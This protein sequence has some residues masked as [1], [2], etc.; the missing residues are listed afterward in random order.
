M[1]FEAHDKAHSEGSTV[2]KRVP[3][4]FIGQHR[5]GKTSVKNSLRGQ[6]FKVN[7]DS[8]AGKDENSSSFKMSRE[9][10]KVGEKDKDA[11]YDSAFSFEHHLAR[12]TVQYLRYRTI[13]LEPRGA[14]S[15]ESSNPKHISNSPESKFTASDVTHTEIH[16]PDMTTEMPKDHQ[17]GEK[18]ESSENFTN[19]AHGVSDDSKS[20]EFLRS[21]TEVL[22]QMEVEEEDLYSMLWDFNGESINHTTYPVFLTHKAVYILVYDLSQNATAIAKPVIKQGRYR[23]RED[24]HFS[25]TNLDYLKFWMSSVAS[26]ASQHVNN[27]SNSISEV[28]PEKL[29]PV[30]LVFT[31]ADTLGDDVDA[32]KI[33]RDVYGS[34]KQTPS[35]VH[36]YKDFFVV[37]TT[38]SGQEFECSEIVRLRKEVL[39]VCSELP[40]LRETIPIQSLIFEKAIQK[41]K[42]EGH[43]FVSLE[44]ARLLAFEECNISDEKQFQRAI[45]FLHEQRILI[46]FDET[47]EL[48]RLVILD[49][50]WLLNVFKGVMS[51]KLYEGSENIFEHLWRKLETEGILEE[52][53]LEYVWGPLHDK[54]NTYESL[55]A[56]M[57]KFSLICPLPSLDHSCGKMYL[58]PSMLMS[59][60]TEGITSLVAAARIPPIFLTFESGQVPSGLFLR[61]ALQL[62][63]WNRKNNPNSANFNFYSNYARFY[64]SVKEKCSVILR[65]YSSYIEVVVHGNN[66]NHESEDGSRSELDLRG[67]ESLDENCARAVRRQL[68]VI[69]NSMHSKFFWPKNTTCRVSF[70]CP[71]CCQ[72]GGIVER[73]KFHLE[74]GC[75]Q[76]ECLHFLSESEICSADIIYCTRNAVAQE[77]R[78]RKEQFEP[79]IKTISQQVCY[80]REL[81]T[82]SILI[83]S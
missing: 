39:A 36:L 15:S 25:K 40:Q 72:N 62:V 68:D 48:N 37:D 21:L 16:D 82:R 24:S 51:V 9:I 58:E 45:N 27:P 6:P 78:V 69:V 46:H 64:P 19:T 75:K 2:V 60:P 12:S 74:Q 1:A 31:H 80:L 81:P 26:S 11:N 49:F 43:K 70:M 30:L 33:V 42:E 83:M 13:E 67:Q 3:I 65:C 56:I 7:E 38:K 73:C 8:I 63:Q 44:D 14:I 76:E 71:I 79:W 59:Y 66:R 4:I 28:L 47:P 53:L 23:E 20:E 17:P 61:I 55:L 32:R 50:E 35:G 34:L 54:Q 5:S 57:E 77:I 29:P 22:L 18:P 52:N 41:K 10:W